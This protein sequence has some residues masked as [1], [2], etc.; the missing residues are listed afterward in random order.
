MTRE[1]GDRCRSIAV[2]ETKLILPHPVNSSAYRRCVQNAAE[3]RGRK[4]RSNRAVLV[5]LS[6]MAVIPLRSA[7]GVAAIGSSSVSILVLMITT[8]RQWAAG[9]GQWCSPTASAKMH[10]T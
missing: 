8:S 10:S 2:S 9:K 6:L 7:A 1:A 3:I 5:G 4:R